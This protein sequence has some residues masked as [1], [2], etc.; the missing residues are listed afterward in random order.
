MAKA[1]K[2]K[3]SKNKNIEKS[4][5]KIPIWKYF[6]LYNSGIHKYTRAY[7]EAQY[8]DIML[9]KDEWDTK[10]NEYMEDRK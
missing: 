3:A 6:Q 2:T 4:S 7:V 5:V 8:R 10:L 1:N 9:S